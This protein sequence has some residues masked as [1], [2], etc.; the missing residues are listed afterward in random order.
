[1]YVCAISGVHKYSMC[2]YIRRKMIYQNV[3]IQS[4]V[5]R[6]V[7]FGRKLIGLQPSRL[8]HFVYRINKHQNL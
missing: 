6:I 4:Q 1:M 8:I 5:L 2:V 7:D 3:D